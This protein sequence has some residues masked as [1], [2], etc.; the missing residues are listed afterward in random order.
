MSCECCN[1]SHI[2]T[3]DYGGQQ[4]EIKNSFPYEVTIC[5]ESIISKIEEEAYHHI[6]SLQPTP[7]SYS[8]PPR[9][10]IGRTSSGDT[11]EELIQVGRIEVPDPPPDLSTDRNVVRV[12]F[13][14]DRTGDPRILEEDTHSPSEFQPDPQWEVSSTQLRFDSSA[15]I[16]TECCSLCEFN[17]G[18]VMTRE[19]VDDCCLWRHNGPE[20]DVAPEYVCTSCTYGG[21]RCVDCGIS[22]RYYMACQQSR[23]YAISG[24]WELH[25]T[26]W[27]FTTVCHP[28]EPNETVCPC[29]AVSR[30]ILNEGEWL[31]NLIPNEYG[32]DGEDG[33]Y[34]ESVYDEDGTYHGEYENGELPEDNTEKMKAV[35]EAVQDVGEFVF[36][37]QDKLPEG[38]YLE[39]MNLLQKVTNVANS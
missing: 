38:D 21:V 22:E 11:E 34:W 29:C 37:L 1:D 15:V 27:Q 12:L 31:E 25:T 20:N 14:E 9:L 30:G 17:T 6:C 39:L 32:E 10:S 2:R 5:V 24:V 35:K 28:E 16:G 18:C 13:E 3:G 26:D 36:D 7:P 8:P 33:A 19:G 23:T 4:E